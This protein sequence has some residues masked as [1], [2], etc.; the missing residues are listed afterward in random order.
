MPVYFYRKSISGGN[1]GRS[2]PNGLW[3]WVVAIL[4]AIA[5]IVLAIIAIPLAFM[6]VFGILS[7]M[8]IGLIA[9]YIWLGF[10][11]GWRNLWDI[12]KMMFGF[13]SS[14]RSGETNWQRV[15]RIWEEQ[16][17]GRSGVWEK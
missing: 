17:K 8:F 5:T 4:V 14:R 3:E 12:T 1:S 15:G 10:R 9:G 6:F 2:R 13:G 11:I 7:L 16:V